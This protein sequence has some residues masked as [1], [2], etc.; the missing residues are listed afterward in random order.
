LGSGGLGC[1][2]ALSLARLGVGR[3]I[4]I[5]KDVVEISNLNRQVLFSHEDVGKP[6]AEV[7]R[8]K[9][10]KEHLIDKEAKVEAYVFDAVKNWNRV[11]EFA[12]ESTVVFNMIDVG[13]YFDAAVQSLCMIRKLPLILGGTFC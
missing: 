8:D 3:I 4:L 5:D 9:I 11:V 12:K 6:K 7:A 10:L 1:T 2:V 13:D